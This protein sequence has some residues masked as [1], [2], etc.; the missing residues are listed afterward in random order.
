MY[1]IY[2]IKSLKTGRHY[3]GHSENLNKRLVAHN[4]GKVRSTK[5][6]VPWK[7]VY[8]EEYLARSE[9]FKRELEIKS[10]K[11]GIKFKQLLGLW[12]RA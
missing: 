4:S 1:K 10:Y 5:S 12:K 11:G 3:I 7:V 2:I 6:G 8:T 9:A